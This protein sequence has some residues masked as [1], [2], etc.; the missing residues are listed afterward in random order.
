MSLSLIVQ[1]RFHAGYSLLGCL[2]RKRVSDEHYAEGIFILALS[3]I[4]VGLVL[5]FYLG[6]AVVQTAIQAFPERAEDL[7]FMYLMGQVAASILFF[8]T[9]LF[10]F[11]PAVKVTVTGR[12]ID[13][14][15]G[16]RRHVVSLDNIQSISS[17]S[18]LLFHQHY[19]RYKNTK[20]FY[21]RLPAE[22]LLIET[23]S[24]P[25]V[26]GLSFEGQKTLTSRLESLTAVPSIQP[27]LKSLSSL[28]PM[29][30]AP[31]PVH[32]LPHRI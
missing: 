22:L 2:I 26:L 7:I 1:R 23:D 13:I 29:S 14:R 12:Q 4:G 28:D 30:E 32:P 18:A 25:V 5:F 16:R 21:G 8:A 3:M 19:R 15:Q 9:C 10:G 6:W 20:G 17:I 31:S 27:G 24:D 11:K